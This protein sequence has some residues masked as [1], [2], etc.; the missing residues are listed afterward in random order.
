MDGRIEKDSLGEVSVPKKMLY[1]AQTQRSF[2]NFKIGT[3][4]MPIETIH[5]LVIIKKSAAIA[6]FELNFLSEEKKD[7]IVAACDEVL[8]NDY[9]SHFP[10]V[11]WQTGSGTQSNMNV[12]EVI[13]N[14]S[15]QKSGGELGSKKPIHPNDDVNMSQSSNDVFPSAMHI[16]ATL[17]IYDKL[18]PALNTFMEGLKHKEKEFKGAIKT[19]RT[20]LM[21]AAPLS[22]EQEF[23]GY[24]SQ[25]EHIMDSLEHCLNYLSELP[26]GGTAVG[27]GLN[28]PK[29][30]TAK[31]IEKINK[32][33][34]RH[35]IPSANKFEGISSKGAIL[36]ASSTLKLLASVLMKI[37]NDIRWS[38]SGPRCGI[39][40]LIIPANEPGSSIMPGKVNP[41]QCEAMTMVAT[42]VYGNDATISFAA[43]QGNFQL[44]VFMPV[45]IYNLLQSIHLLSDVMVNFYQKCL[46]G[47][48]I[49]QEN[50]EKHLKNNLILA[51]AL[52][53][54]IGY[55]N[56]SKIVKK[57]AKENISLKKAAID[58]GILS[59]EKFDGIV[60]PQKMI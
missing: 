50:T 28:A 31:I 54:E 14:L 19:G 20:H 11:V 30:F 34:G 55:D 43:S 45:M 60:D 32:E 21:D 38:A 8:S 48:K 22:F 58:L 13:S 16:S 52:N 33:T 37:A 10:L 36:E 23:S 47:L 24:R 29:G 25:I 35:F 49:H 57:A 12:N 15:I 56:A 3:E 1:G 18:I 6:N 5:A 46:K 39:G 9:I 2:E 40:E 51:T 59:A 27:T 26:I 4:K 17:L 42:Q 41:T 7:L 53:R 44:N